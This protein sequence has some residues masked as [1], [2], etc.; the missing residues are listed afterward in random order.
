MVSKRRL[1]SVIIPELGHNNGKDETD[2]MERLIAV[3]FCFG[4]ICLVCAV[5]GFLA[6]YAFPRFLERY[7][8]KLPM[9]WMHRKG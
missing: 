3:L 4:V 7:L 9:M 1:Q 8:D 5:G 2:T 6:D